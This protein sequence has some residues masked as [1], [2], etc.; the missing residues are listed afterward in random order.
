M[1]L[2]LLLALIRTFALA[3][4]YW[5]P[6]AYGSDLPSASLPIE[7]VIDQQIESAITEAGVTP[8]EQADDATVI[9]RL[10]LDLVGR[11]PTTGE[12]DA[13]TKS[14]DSD[15]RMKLVDRLMSSPGFARHQAAQFDVMLNPDSNM[16]GSGAFR[17]YLT[18]SLKEN[19]P[20]DK[21]FREV[22]LPNEGDAKFKGAAEFLRNRVTDAD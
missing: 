10:T 15:K 11:I 1:R 8:A 6:L 20:W 19:K 4:T 16:R 2:R 9:R 3:W 21:L 18:A 7:K 5:A 13:Y 17:E 22:L 14:T 12:V